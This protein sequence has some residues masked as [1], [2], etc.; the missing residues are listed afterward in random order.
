MILL[1]LLDV[2]ESTLHVSSA[3]GQVSKAHIGVRVA[4][5]VLDDAF[6]HLS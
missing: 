3:L 5:L 6:E 2:F 1:A 4:W